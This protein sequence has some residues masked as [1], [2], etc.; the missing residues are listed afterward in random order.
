MADLL[1]TGISGLLSARAALDTTGHN[2]TNVDTPGYSRQSVELETRE[3]DS[4]GRY[5][6][7]N[8]V[9]VVAV[10][11]AYSQYLATAAREQNAG[12]ARAKTFGSL[13]GGVN[14]LFA[15]DANVQTALD[16]FYGSVQDVA[17]DPTSIPVR[18]ALLG[19]AQSL[20]S[21]FHTLD[22]QLALKSSEVNGRIGEDVASINSLAGNIA[23]L[24][25]QIVK[26]Y[27]TGDTPNDLL[28]QRGAA[29]QK[30]SAKV[31][32]HVFSEGHAIDVSVGTGQALV[33]GTQVEAL[34]TVP[35][36]Y[37]SSQVDV[38][39][40]VGHDITGQLSGGDLGGLLDFRGA[41]L[42]SARDRLGQAALA[43][44]HAVNDQHHQGMD[45]N[46]ELGGDLFTVPAPQVLPASG[47]GGSAS[48]SA[49]VT[50]TGALTGNNYTL[51][52]SG[53]TWSVDTGVSQLVPTSGSGTVADPLLFDGLKVVVSGT[54]NNGDSFRIQPTRGNAG[55]IQL[56]ITDP[57]KLAL[58]TPVQAAAGNDNQ[59]QVAAISVDDA[60]DPDLLA[61]VQ[62][63]FTAPDTYSVNGSGSFTYTGG[64]IQRDGWSLSLDGAPAAGDSF[65]V[66][67]N[68]GGVGDNRNALAIGNTADL[69]VLNGGIV[70]AG[71]A[72]A[73]L[74][75]DDGT[76]GAQAK[77]ELSAQT[78]LYN[79]ATKAEQSVS[80][81][82]L[83][84]EA[85]NL[86]RYQQSYQASA[87]V[88][89]TANTLFDSLLDAIR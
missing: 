67:A 20:V 77:V 28:D 52:Y 55:G 84:E 29:L 62:I 57:A 32:I 24:N 13:V 82:S 59:A 37:D 86:V 78:S 56:A 42:T 63:D 22:H 39:T 6:I 40:S 75:A 44:T 2:I 69:G 54:P 36:A 43:F 16:S 31:G 79:Q 23:K 51:R 38:L 88:I 18:Q 68:T 46:G 49:S 5:S 34:K 60:A 80:G 65:R 73:S 72:Y 4:M 71:A 76:V 47:N 1:N 81:V 30:L 7:G 89:A 61:P 58:A 41:V 50:D 74:V 26:A 14:D 35:D 27:A 66:S 11:R 87:K 33:Q 10:K 83:E 45:L 19:K 3:P 15:G 12:L 64:T 21:T 25:Q 70:S 17:N 53:G 8:G 85:A 48:A 9:D